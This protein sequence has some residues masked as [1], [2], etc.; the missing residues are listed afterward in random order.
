[1]DDGPDLDQALGFSEAVVQGVGKPVQQRAAKGAMD[2]GTSSR[3]LED[4]VEGALHVAEKVL[5]ELCAGGLIPCI[6][7]GDVIVG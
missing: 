7:L 6:R 3:I 1:M 2:I 4:E 5:A